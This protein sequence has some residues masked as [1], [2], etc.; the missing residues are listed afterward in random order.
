M[1]CLNELVS[2]GEISVGAR[3]TILA[4]FDQ[5]VFEQ[6]SEMQKIKPTTISGECIN[7]NNVDEIWKF[8]LKNMEIRDDSFRESSD[9][10]N[11]VS[12]NAENNLIEVQ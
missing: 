3:E 9:R 7:Y 2:A 5:K 10:C 12:M 6:F 8:E 11:V 1:D 4:T